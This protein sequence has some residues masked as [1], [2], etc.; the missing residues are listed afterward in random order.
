MK[1]KEIIKEPQCESI[2][3]NATMLGDAPIMA[4][5]KLQKRKHQ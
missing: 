4:Q 5:N 3:G 1:R 2:K